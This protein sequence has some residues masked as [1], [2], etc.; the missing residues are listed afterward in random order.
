MIIKGVNMNYA[1]I[2]EALIEK[3]SRRTID[4]YYEIHHII[5]KCIGGRDDKTNLIALTPEEHFLAHQ[6]LI[7]IYPN[8]NKLVYAAAMMTLHN[9]GNRANN[10]LYGWLKR[11]KNEEVSVSM[12]NDWV[13]NRDKRLKAAIEAANR[14]CIKEGNRSRMKSFW[15]SDSPDARRRKDL[16]A[17]TSKKASEI[18]QTKN[19][20]LWKTAEFRDK[21]KTRKRGSNSNSMKEKWADPA[22]KEMMK[23]KRRLKHEAKINQKSG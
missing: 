7:K 13:V 17:S 19:K 4:G 20:E 22:F 9:S 2:Y 14:D 12:R 6:L 21:M 15:G 10:K 3:A 11:K 16:L 8:E 1:K 5:P 18:A 23:E